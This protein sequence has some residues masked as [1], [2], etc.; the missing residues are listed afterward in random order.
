MTFYVMAK[1]L[2]LLFNLN[3]NATFTHPIFVKFR[4]FAESD[5]FD[6]LEYMTFV[7][8]QEA[9]RQI[10]DAKMKITIVASIWVVCVVAIHMIFFRTFVRR[11]R[12]ESEHTFS[13]LRMIPRKLVRDVPEIQAFLRETAPED[14]DFN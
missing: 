13:V 8:Y 7:N 9:L 2:V 14:V 6:G 4:I 3:P 12:D 1:E 10:S 5:L 11:L